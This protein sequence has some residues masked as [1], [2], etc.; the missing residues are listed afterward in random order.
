VLQHLREELRHYRA[1]PGPVHA[2]FAL[3]FTTA[4][5]AFVY[6]FA[7]LYMREKLG[8]PRDRV[9]LFL[10]LFSLSAMPGAL[11]GGKLADR[12]GRRPVVLGVQALAA[13]LLFACFLA[14]SSPVVPWLLCVVWFL[15]GA[16]PPATNAM[17]ADLVDERARPHAFAYLYLGTNL[18]FSLGSGFGGLLFAHHAQLI[19]LGNG[20]AALAALALAAWKLPE[21]R[22][23]HA[24]EV[25]HADRHGLLRAFAGAPDLAAFIAM[26]AL[27]GILFSQS[28]F[29][30]PL[31]VNAVFGSDRGPPVFGTL[32]TTNG[33]VVVMASGLLI[34]ATRR[35]AALPVVAVSAIL[36]AAGM[37]G[38]SMLAT[39]AGFV[40]ATI[41]WTAGEILVVAHAGVYVANRSP[42]PLRGRVSSVHS[43]CFS[44]GLAA[45]PAI[46]GAC[47]ESRGATAAWSL[48][49]SIGVATALGMLVLRR[50]ETGRSA[51]VPQGEPQT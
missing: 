31:Q 9:G 24:A 27:F 37:G 38:Y 25:A 28:G 40:A 33:L 49:A 35:H 39:H 29:L 50:Y 46:A 41:V 12:V 21:T 36:F 47:L 16:M 48:V 14:G 4:A 1:L 42:P 10:T 30:L 7:T 3:R 11:A 51:P 6:A 17:L 19:F 22:P 20:A 13:V 45:G 23:A 43:T 8:L 2:L 44:A 15:Q 32:M 18:G 34:A 5:G 26:Q